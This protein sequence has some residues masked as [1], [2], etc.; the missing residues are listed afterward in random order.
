MKNILV[1]TE[2]RGVWFCQV[3]QDKDLTPTTLTDLKNARMAIYWNT[4]NGFHELCEIG[5]NRGS[6]ISSIAD[7]EVLHKITG[8]FSV[9][10]EAA[11]NWMEWK[12]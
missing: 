6:R 3:P 8:V 7:I 2:H 12:S 5:P 1:T 11:K 10:D 4:K 9:T